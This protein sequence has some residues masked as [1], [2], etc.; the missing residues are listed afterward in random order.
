MRV[1]V[2]HNFYQQPGG[3]DQVFAAECRMLEQHGHDVTRLE[4]HNDDVAYMG[5]LALARA[6]FWNKDSYDRVRALVREKRADVVH[7]HNTFPL[8]SPAAYYAARAEGA[9]VVQS[10]HNYRLLCAGATLFRNGT[11]CE[12]CVGSK[13]NLPAA[14][15]GCYRGSRATSAVTGAMLAGHRLAGTWNRAVDLYLTLSD[16]ARSKFIRGGFEAD[17]IV[18]KPNCVD[19]DPKQGAGK[20]HYALFAAR[21]TEEKGIATL[22]DAWKLIGR[23]LP[24]KIVGDGP[25]MEVVREAARTMPGVEYL[26]RRPMDEVH[27]LMGNAKLVVVPSIWYEGMP[28]TIIEAYATGTPVLASRLG[29]MAELVEHDKTGWL[30][31]PGRAAHM[32]AQVACLLTLPEQKWNAVRAAARRR[33]EA[34]FTAGAIYARLMSAYQLAIQRRHLQSSVGATPALPS[35]QFENT[36]DASVASAKTSVC[37]ARQ[38]MDGILL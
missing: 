13:V 14:V 31:T 21:L 19:P 34:S 26:G 12:K 15:Y 16:F 29:A 7:F 9:A 35:S 33:Y 24:L 5:K 30:V 37:V 18:T 6:T 4:V 36:A 11:V 20:G 17:R 23:S 2:A 25:L 8:L 38:G 32:A 22:L 10:L 1:I 27:R 28:L 3:E